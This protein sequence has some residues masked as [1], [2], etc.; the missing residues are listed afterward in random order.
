MPRS[1]SPLFAKQS[2]RSMG[3][4]NHGRSRT[5]HPLMQSHQ[6]EGCIPT[7]SI[8]RIG[9]C[10]GGGHGRVIVSP[11]HTT[12][13]IG[14]WWNNDGGPVMTG[15]RIDGP[16]GGIDRFDQTG[17]GWFHEETM[18]RMGR[19]IR[20]CGRPSPRDTSLFPDM[21]SQI[22]KQPS[23]T[24]SASILGV[25]V[26]IVCMGV[27]TIKISI[28]IICCCC[29]VRRTQVLGGPALLLF[30]RFPLVVL[31]HYFG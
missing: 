8:G 7:S 22:S 2:R 20:G 19:V 27:E 3:G 6:H 10:S 11:F 28:I 13:M 26:V 15:T 24:T 30:G 18:S 9:G 21:Q 1:L 17:G 12:T 25:V 31:W 29:Y 14:W 5:G 23:S 16:T 4:R